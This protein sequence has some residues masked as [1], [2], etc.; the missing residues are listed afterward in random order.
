MNKLKAAFGSRTV[1]TI[2]IMFVVSGI[3]GIRENLGV[4]YEPLMALLSIAAV[5]FK[6]NPSGHY[7]K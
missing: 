6:I 4:V 5:Y 7:G 3:E 2:A 1:W